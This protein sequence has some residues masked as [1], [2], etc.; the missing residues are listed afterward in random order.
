MF[1]ALTDALQAVAAWLPTWCLYVGDCLGHA[2]LW[3]VALNLFYG[4]PLPRW[5]L[6]FTRKIDI[7]FIL[8]APAIF[9]LALDLGGTGQLEWSSGSMRT[10]LAPYT[11]ICFLFG[12]VIGPI[13]QVRYWLRRTAPQLASTPARIV[14]VAQQLGYRPAAPAN[15]PVYAGCRSTRSSRSSSPRRRWPCRSCPPAWDGLTILHLTDLHLCGTPDRA[16][17]QLRDRRMPAR[18]RAR[19]RRAHRRR[20]RQRLAPSLDRA[21]A[22]PAALEPGRLRHPRQPRRLVR[23]AS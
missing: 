6:K 15:T 18:R 12:L 7:L 20:R 19:P 14:D 5:L 1:S 10:W 17:Y 8:S 9:W 4:N 23:R 3:T 16:F 21:G 11:V 22:G 2:Y 13:A